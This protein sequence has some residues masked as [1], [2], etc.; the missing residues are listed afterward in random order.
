MPQGIKLL[1]HQKYAK[2]LCQSSNV[3]FSLPTLIKKTAALRFVF[4]TF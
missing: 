1:R 3:A 2:M 4:N